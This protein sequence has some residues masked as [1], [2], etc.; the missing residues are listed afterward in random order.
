M[1]NEFGKKMTTFSHNVCLYGDLVL[2]TSQDL[3]CLP[4]TAP[5]LFNKSTKVCSH[6][7][8]IVF[9][10]NAKNKIDLHGGSDCLESCTH[11]SYD[12]K[13]YSKKLDGIAHCHKLRRKT[14]FLPLIL[15]V[16][17]NG[18]PKL[19]PLSKIWG[20]R[21]YSP[22]LSCEYKWKGLQL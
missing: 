13:K 11:L 8:T 10:Y 3:N 9:F 21:S 17:L 16:Y 2:K 6:E 18:F 14:T 19:F 5:N 12:I 22:A 7:D 1:P 20:Y 15:N 4:W